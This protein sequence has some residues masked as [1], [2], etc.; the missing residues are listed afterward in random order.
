MIV[1]VGSILLTV[2]LAYPLISVYLSSPANSTLYTWSPAV[3]NSEG[4]VIF[5]APLIGLPPMATCL[6]STVT[7]T[8]PVASLGNST[9]MFTPSSPTLISSVIPILNEGIVFPTLN[10]AATLDG[11]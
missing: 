7:D 3:N 9:V 6:P 2:N 11:R 8:K 10:D 1:T 5:K 4:T